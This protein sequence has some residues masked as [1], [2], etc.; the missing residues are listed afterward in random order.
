MAAKKV[1]ALIKEARTKAG[2]SQEALAKLV[3]G[4]SASELGKVERGEKDTKGGYA[5]VCPNMKKVTLEKVYSS[6]KN[7]EEQIGL[8]DD[9]MARAAAPMEKML[10]LSK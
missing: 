2:L 9:L 10:D 1:G 6:L 7:N 8:T 3:D 5:M 4:L